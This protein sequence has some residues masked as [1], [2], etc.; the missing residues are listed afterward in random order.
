MENRR[1]A[2]YPVL[3]THSTPSSGQDT[4]SSSGFQVP[5]GDLSGLLIVSGGFPG[6]RRGLCR[7]IFS[8]FH[9]DSDSE[10]RSIIPEL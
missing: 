1:Q 3:L 6:Q 2:D 4:D 5:C 7:R 9:V 8:P 10:G